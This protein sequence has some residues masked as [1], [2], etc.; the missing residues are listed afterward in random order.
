MRRIVRSLRTTVL[1]C[2]LVVGVGGG[3]SREPETKSWKLTY[4]FTLAEKPQSL[5]L[6]FPEF[7]NTVHFD[8]ASDGRTRYC[9]FPFMADSNFAC[10][11]F[12]VSPEAA[13]GLVSRLLEVIPDMRDRYEPYDSKE[14]RRPLLTG[15]FDG[16]SIQFQLSPEMN[17][18]VRGIFQ[19]LIDVADQHDW[20]YNPIVRKSAPRTRPNKTDAGDGK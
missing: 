15:Y 9:R 12:S 13:D 8:I 3:C 1:L 20:T 6:P 14:P 2:Y 5:S 4:I 11:E 7:D 19:P 18:R 10:K 16:T 17:I